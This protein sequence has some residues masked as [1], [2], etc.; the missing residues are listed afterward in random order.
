MLRFFPET[1]ALGEKIVA[2]LRAEGISCGMRG[3]G[4]GPTGTKRGE[5]GV[6]MFSDHSIFTVPAY[7]LETVFDPTGAGDTFAGGFMGYL[8]STRNLSDASIRQ[9]IVFGCVMAS[10]TVEDFSLNR[11]KTLDYVEVEERY[12]KFKLLT[13]FDGLS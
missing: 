13:D 7:P 4:A 2:A 5:Y 6:I 8:A 3:A 11:L 12:R 1:I 9:A 10:F